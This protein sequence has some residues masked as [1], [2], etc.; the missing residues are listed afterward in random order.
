MRLIPEGRREQTGL[1]QG[2][3]GKR[4]LQAGDRDFLS[5]GQPGRLLLLAKTRRSSHASPG[6]GGLS[7]EHPTAQESC[8]LGLYSV[9]DIGG[10][11]RDAPQSQGG[12]RRYDGQAWTRQGCVTLKAPGCTGFKAT[13]GWGA[14][15]DAWEGLLWAGFGR[16][17]QSH[18]A[19][20]AEE[21]AGTP[22]LAQ[23]SCVWGASSSPSLCLRLLICIMGADSHNCR[24]G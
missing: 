5:E 4:P 20:L 3:A 13:P 7:R 19:W 11:F 15:P 21:G 18:P 14:D 24:E 16:S 1:T 17:R 8:R 23:A 12:R 9:A 10:A 22:A 2:P 6:R